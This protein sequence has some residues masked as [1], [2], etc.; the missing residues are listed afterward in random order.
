MIERTDTG[1]NRRGL[2]FVGDSK[3][4]ALGTRAE[5]MRRGHYYLSPLP[6]NQ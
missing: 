2:L 1:L 3:M 4:S 6:F 5:I